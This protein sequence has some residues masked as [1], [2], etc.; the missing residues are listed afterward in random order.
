ME[1]LQLLQKHDPAYIC[2]QELIFGSR[3]LP[4]PRGYTSFTSTIRGARRCGHFAPLRTSLHAVSVCI[5]LCMDN[6]VE[7]LHQ[8]PEPF[9]LVGD[10][11]IHHSS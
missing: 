11:N 6:L 8:L 9:L 3:F 1:L 5:H 2:L 4:I 10:F 7:L